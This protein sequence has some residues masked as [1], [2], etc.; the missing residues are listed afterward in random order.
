MAEGGEGGSTVQHTVLEQ[1]SSAGTLHGGTPGAVESEVPKAMESGACAAVVLFRL[2]R[3][4]IAHAGDCRVVLGMREASTHD[5]GGEEEAGP[6]FRPLD[7]T[8]DHKLSG[9]EAERVRRSG[10]WISEPIDETGSDFEHCFEPSRV[11]VGEGKRHLGP[12][13]TM[14]R[15]LGDLDAD[16]IGVIPTPEV[17]FRTLVGGRDRFVVLAS[18]GLWEF[19]PSATVVD[20][21]GDFLQRGEPAIH[22]ARFLIAM[23]AH[24]WQTEE[25]GYRDDITAVVVYLDEVSQQIEASCSSSRPSSGGVSNTRASPSPATRKPPAG[26]VGAVGTPAA[27]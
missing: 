5:E 27:S 17:S 6:T 11:Y 12:G 4:I 10:G 20:V 21:V 14:S 26:A 23:A 2:R 9:E 3:L 24:A 13:L 22:A 1:G 16:G 8:A 25:G 19:L 15:S 18:D 7:L